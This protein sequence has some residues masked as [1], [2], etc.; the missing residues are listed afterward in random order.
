MR[1]TYN[2]LTGCRLISC[3]DVWMTAGI[4]VFSDWLASFFWWINNSV[5]SI[6]VLNTANRIGLFEHLRAELL[7]MDELAKRCG[8]RPCVSAKRPTKSAS[9]NRC[10][11]TS[12]SIQS[13][14]KFLLPSWASCHAWLRT[15]FST[16]TVLHP[17]RWRS[18]L[19]ATSSRR[20]PPPASGWMGSEQSR[21][22]ERH[23]SRGNGQRGM[24]GRAWFPH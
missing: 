11:S 10:S 22:A 6:L 18:S 1:A 14:P 24:I 20:C 7:P 16:N 3:I 19:A 8:T 5:C 17:S 15:L 21:R 13:A 9:A 4:A 12:P 2:T 23:R